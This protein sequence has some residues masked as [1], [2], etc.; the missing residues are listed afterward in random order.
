[1]N[2]KEIVNIVFYNFYE[3][4]KEI[5]QAC[6]FYSDGT[7][8]N[9]SFDEGIDYTLDLLKKQKLTTKE[10]SNIIN[11]RNIYV[12]SGVELNNNFKRFIVKQNSNNLET[13]KQ[14]EKVN[15]STEKVI[16]LPEK[17]VD[18]KNL[19]D[20]D[21]LAKTDYE[22]EQEDMSEDNFKEEVKDTKDEAKNKKG[23]FA[24]KVANFF[25]GDKNFKDRPL[26]VADEI[27]SDKNNK[28]KKAGLFTKMKNFLHRSKVR[29]GAAVM[30]LVVLVGGGSF[31]AGKNSGKIGKFFSNKIAKTNP[32]EPDVN[33][34]NN[35]VYGDNDYYDGYT[36][37][38]LQE[39]NTNE[40]QKNAM[41]NIR[42]AFQKFNN[43]FA[44]SHV[45]EGKNIKAALSWTEMNSLQQ[46]YNNY[47]VE[48]IAAIFNGSRIN[49]NEFSQAYKNANLQLMGAHVIETR[50]NPVDLSILINSEEGKN[51]YQK[52]HEM[53]LQLKESEG[54]DRIDKVNAWRQALLEDFPISDDIRE[55]GIAHSDNRLVESYKLSIVPMVSAVEIMY[56]NLATDN[57]LSEKT[58]NY[59]NDTGLCNLADDNFERI[60]RITEITPENNA[61]PL[62]IQY[63]N[64][65]TLELEAENNYNIADEYRELTK[66]DAFQEAVNQHDHDSNISVE[67][68]SYVASGNVIES[69]STVETET[70][71]E[72]KVEK[73]VEK[74]KTSDEKEAIKKSSKKKVEEAKEKVDKQIEEENQKAKEEGLQ[75][76]EKE[77]EK[78]Q[79]QEDKKAE[80]IEQQIAQ[81]DNDMQQDIADANEKIEQNNSDTDPS[82]DVPINESDFGDHN[83]DFDDDH[84]D[85]NGNLDNSVKD[86]TTD[87]TNDQS[88]EELPDPNVTGAAFEESY[89]KTSV[90][91]EYVPETQVPVE[92]VPEVVEPVQEMPTPVDPVPEVVETVQEMPA[93]VDPVPEVVESVPEV[94]ETIP[95]I[96]PE[97]ISDQSQ[98]IIEYEEPVE[99]SVDYTVDYTDYNT[100]MENISNEELADMIV[101]SMADYPEEEYTDGY[102]YTLQ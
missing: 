71:T 102:Q 20:Y 62:Y 64:A 68:S 54:Q 9:C 11:N 91:P 101:E 35:L 66:L 40:V 10:L 41:A 61:E 46:A 26:K 17:K 28:G 27:A 21:A 96:A 53:F 60:E 4:Q 94:V 56:Q 24:P 81:D 59:F 47:S 22:D 12:M 38:Q 37:E 19:S 83:V 85:S 93:P 80:A 36:F 78:I 72:T 30:A 100:G 63:E 45:E 99:E 49:A 84:S 73:K 7:V 25:N 51:F 52:Y 89:P 14:N 75:Q 57:T 2:F 98:T 88:N 39:V 50:Q 79:E 92:P 29:I 1:M 67:P 70:E 86:I 6:V 32:D 55:V 18:D 95:E 74:T 5:R 31:L 82:N 13:T 15:N 69:H 34:E 8:K 48:E 58:I 33:I 43:E 65:I 76:A 42:G 16:S 23:G 87:G 77:L 90:D 3:G 44:N 97:E